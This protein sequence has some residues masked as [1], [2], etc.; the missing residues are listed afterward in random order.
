MHASALSQVL[1]YELM[2]HWD[3]NEGGLERHV[4]EVERFYERRRDLMHEAA[5]RHLTGLCDWELPRAGMFLWI[6]VRGV[7][8]TWSMIM[9]DGLQENI[10]LVP[11]KV[12]VPNGATSPYLRASYSI[13]P[14]E[15]FD[16][17]FR[18]LANIIRRAQQK[19]KISASGENKANV[20]LAQ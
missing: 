5:I 12:F 14:E 19:Q 4:H 9:D 6:R 3:Q 15:K 10:M 1:V 20:S 8:D 7:D 17:A 16:E 13:A 18:R 2:R 11:G